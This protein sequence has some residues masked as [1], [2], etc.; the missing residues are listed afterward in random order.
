MS[1]PD[2]FCYLVESPRK[3][4]CYMYDRYYEL[5]LDYHIIRT[6]QPLILGGRLMSIWPN[7]APTLLFMRV[8]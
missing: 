7:I 2:I 6:L 3:R 4:H 1:V 5:N 8:F